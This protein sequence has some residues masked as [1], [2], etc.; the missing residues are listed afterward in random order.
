MTL[1]L[2]A[3]VATQPITVQVHTLPHA[4]ADLPHYATAGSAGMDIR[5][6]IDAPLTLGSLER[7]LVPTGLMMMI[8]EGYECQIRPRSG[9]SIKLGLTLV[10]CVGTI[11]SDYRDEVKVA[12]IN[13]SQVPVTIQP[14]E[15]I[16][17]LLF[18][19]VT[20]AQ[21]A[22]V[23]LGNIADSKAEL[24]AQGGRQ[25]GFGSTGVH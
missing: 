16:A 5:A 19:P 25:G 2:D 8:P 18:A 20:R 23:S 22:T 9:L 7:T 17:Q 3:P 21:W 4:P 1:T 11:D 13:L 24:T 6:A 12:L 14:G 15:R 10:N